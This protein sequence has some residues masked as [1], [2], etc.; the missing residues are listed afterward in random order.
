MKTIDEI[1]IE[2]ICNCLAQGASFGEAARLASEN[3]D[4]C[5][6]ASAFEQF[7]TPS[8]VM[9]FSVADAAVLPDSFVFLPSDGDTPVEAGAGSLLDAA[10]EASIGVGRWYSADAGRR[11][12]RVA[13]SHP[14]NN[15]RSAKPG[16]RT[17]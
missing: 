13:S 17:G 9:G 8:P 7:C 5:Q 14:P 15:F 16:P 2:A 4:S 10:T 3:C 1:K 12:S 6:I 11:T